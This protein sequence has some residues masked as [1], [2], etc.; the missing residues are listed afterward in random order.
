MKVTVTEDQYLED[1]ANLLRRYRL[2]PG[3]PGALEELREQLQSN[4]ALRGDLFNLCTAISHMGETDLSPE[5]MLNLVARALVGPR[6][7][8]RISEPEVPD[9]VRVVFLD[10]YARWFNRNEARSLGIELPDTNS[11]ALPPSLTPFASAASMA[12]A[13][14]L[15]AERSG[16]RTEIRPET[17]IGELTISELRSYLDEIESRVGRLQPY[18]QTLRSAVPEVPAQREPPASP[19]APLA[20]SASA[21]PAAPTARAVPERAADIPPVRAGHAADERVETR[22]Q[23]EPETTPF[24]E[25]MMFQRGRTQEIPIAGTSSKRVAQKRE[26]VRLRP[27]EPTSSSQTADPTA[28]TG[29]AEPQRLGQM[30]SSETSHR[31][32]QETATEATTLERLTSPE[33]KPESTV[34]NVEA[35]VVETKADVLTSVEPVPLVLPVRGRVLTEETEADESRVSAEPLMF[36]GMEEPNRGGSRYVTAIAASLLLVATTGAAGYHFLYH[37]S[38]PTPVQQ[39]AEPAP[40]PVVPDTT[41]ADA[42]ATMAPPSGQTSA[43][44]AAAPAAGAAPAAHK[45]R[46]L[47]HAAEVEAEAA[48]AQAESDSRD[49]SATGVVPQQRSSS[50]SADNGSATTPPQR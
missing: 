40:A 44:G 21:A 20:Q 31:G 43:P 7:F 30:R 36:R 10:E 12:G 24:A 22:R 1:I 5:E 39:P 3:T 38:L 41:P 18:L 8:R 17:P 33:S 11:A 4:P 34:E 28:L 35:E 49:G 14:R 19:V 25:P 50:P 29:V 27:E 15:R 46:R 37:R 13:D 42:P 9:P 23:V 6:S 26:R 16:A 48:R 2:S 45:T 47:S 32:E